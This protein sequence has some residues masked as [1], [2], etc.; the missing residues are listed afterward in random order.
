MPEPSTLASRPRHCLRAGITGNMGSGKTTVC[1]IFEALGVPVYDADHWAKFL[2]GHDPALMAGI[3]QLFGPA[4]YTAEGAYDRAYVAARA[5]SDPARLQ[6]LNAL[7][8]PAVEAHSRAW[9]EGQ[10]AAG[11]PY[12]LKEAALLVESGG[13][14]HLDALI[15]V[16]APEALRI[17]RVME[18]DG[19]DEAAIRARLRHQRPEAEKTALADFI[20]RN[21]GR[22]HLI[23]QVL[24]IHRELLARAGAG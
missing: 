22:M 1:R 23:P 10:A 21:D 18:R 11:Q 7:V 5:F 15:V 19:L 6:A 14:R 20:V 2:I 12:T 16:A 17:R 13:H 8:H 3:R 4:A 24:A 9:H